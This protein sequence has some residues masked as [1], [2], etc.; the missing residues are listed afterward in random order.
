MEEPRKDFSSLHCFF[1]EKDAD[2]DKLNAL[3]VQPSKSSEDK[4]DWYT[5]EEGSFVKDIVDEFKNNSLK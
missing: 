5:I 4:Q 3:K 1:E 2:G